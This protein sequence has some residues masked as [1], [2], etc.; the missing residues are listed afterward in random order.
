MIRYH[1]GLDFGKVAE[2]IKEINIKLGEVLHS[3]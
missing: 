1:G 3:Y 2:A